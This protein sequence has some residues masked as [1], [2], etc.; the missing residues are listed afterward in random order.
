M[1]EMA[2]LK[3][4]QLEPAPIAHPDEHVLLREQIQSKLTYALGKSFRSATDNDWYHATALA[5]RDRIVDIWLASRREAKRLKKKRVYYLSIEFLIGRLLLDTL[6]NLRLVEPAR[7]ALAGMGVD[8]DRLRGHEPDA[9]LG[10]GGLGRLAACFMDSMSALGIPAYGYGIRY[11]NGLFEQRIVDGWQH[12]LPED[13]LAAGNPW[14]FM[15]FDIK[16]PVGFGG[17][18]EFVGDTKATMHAV[19]TPAETI[20]AIPYDTP[21]AG[22][23]GRHA[24]ALRLW[25]ARVADPIHLATFNEGDLVGATAAR[26]RAEAISRVL[27]PND[28]TPV[29][30]ELRLRQEYFFT[31]A[32]LQ[33][34][35]KRHID[36]FGTIETL[37]DYAAVQLNDTHPAIAVAEL[38]RILV[39]DHQ[40]EWTRAWAITRAT[41]SY[42]NHT[43]L[44]EALES[45]P[46][47]LL[48]RLLPRHLQIIYTINWIH[49][50]D[51][52]RR[53]LN[54]PAFIASTSLVQDN[55]ERRVRM[56]HLAF[57]GT[58]CVNGVSALHT[59]LLKDT[60][61]HDLIKASPPQATTQVVNKTNGITF[62]RWLYEA[63]PVLTG[64]LVEQLGERVLD[65]PDCLKELEKFAEDDGFVARY[66]YARTANKS[67]LAD[68][69]ET[70]TGIEVNPH[71]LFDVHIK[72]IHEYKRQLLNLLE[73]IALYQEIKARPNDEFVPRVKIF[74]GKA[75]AS[76]ERAKLIIKLAGDIGR[77]VNNDPV[78]AGRLKLVFI[79]NYSASLAEAII[80]AADL[81]EQISTAG[82]E[83]SG[84]GN[85][86]LALNG[87]ITI[88]T[89]DGAN[90]EISEQVGRENLVIFGM[91]A[92]E[93]AER[94]QA[95]FIGADAVAV[96]PRLRRALESLAS[97]A[98]SPEYPDRF[99]SIVEA[100][101]GY[102]RFMVAADFDAY[103]EAQR[104][105]DQLW[106]MPPA[107]WRASIL[108]TA[109]MGWFSSDR[110][111]REY[112]RE[113]W[114]VPVA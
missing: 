67:R 32:T 45:W 12:E 73:T 42:T 41:L 71:A 16:Y 19:W 93:V 13:W 28:G 62:R 75:A 37:A 48:G 17:S 92:A 1:V 81:S 69:L 61:F 59:E 18:V 54:D 57:L 20:L 53:G 52:E 26:V 111:I 30:Q 84:T 38:M 83:A 79:P 72:R 46:V 25:S 7:E 110:T 51:L 77:V 101:R 63:N 74:A 33:D 112:A 58:H 113:I 64:L 60:V 78:I 107:W 87:A 103:W 35:T 11:E 80:P 23:R 98:F 2:Q 49:L 85:M 5:V 15:R 68:L 114:D 39:D 50:Q 82:M 66:E 94:Q 70:K 109:R 89:L 105:V 55:G 6:T 65:H 96:S 106:R 8:L 104:S 91:T 86:K 29:G 88:G 34:V 44:P 95:G 108:N 40:I 97:G 14:E 56:A 90:I 10:N 76:Y 9:A 36:D 22:W 3:R 21:I 24:N 31:S 4:T 27:Y 99:A 102:D 47:D 100:V 43:L